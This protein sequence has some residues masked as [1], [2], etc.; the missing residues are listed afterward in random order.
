MNRVYAYLRASTKEQDP[1]RAKN[2]LDKFCKENNLKI[3]A[4]FYE[5]ESGAKLERPELFRLLGI[6]EKGDILLVEQVDRIS[7]LKGDDWELLKSMIAQ[8]GIKV[9]ALDLPTSHNFLG[10]SDTFTDRMLQALNNMMLD[11]LAAIARKDFE[12]RRNR[13]KEGIKR[14]KKNGLYRG[15]QVDKKLQSN[16]ERLLKSGSS[17]NEIIDTLGCGRATVAKV[18]KRLKQE[19]YN[20]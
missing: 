18:S 4:Y 13:Q 10:K 2:V 14:A 17:Y 1:K 7:R 11:M 15:R 19:E 5:N 3:S 6:A 20:G 12:D 9:V 16:I 8:K